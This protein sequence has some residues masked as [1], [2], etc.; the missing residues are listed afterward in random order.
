VRAECRGCNGRH[1]LM[2]EKWHF[3]MHFISEM[4]FFEAFG[5]IMHCIFK[6]FW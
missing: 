2:P 1:F 4:P 6:A 3:L 5:K